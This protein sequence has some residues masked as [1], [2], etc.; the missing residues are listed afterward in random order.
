MAWLNLANDIRQ[1][2]Y[3]QARFEH[4]ENV[5][6]Q[7]MAKNFFVTKAKCK[8]ISQIPP[9]V[10]LETF[11]VTRFA[12]F[13][14]IGHVIPSEAFQSFKLD[15]SQSSPNQACD[16]SSTQHDTPRPCAV[17]TQIA[18]R[19]STHRTLR[20]YARQV[21]L[22]KESTKVRY[23]FGLCQ[24]TLTARKLRDFTDS[25]HNSCQMPKIPLEIRHVQNHNGHYQQDLQRI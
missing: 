3:R 2:I 21:A 8:S 4:F 9:G 15:I 12:P 22:D 19:A 18:L 1:T 24:D 13:L 5:V 11:K 23:D 14:S 25:V 6:R 17:C 16:M 20:L 7:K 10:E